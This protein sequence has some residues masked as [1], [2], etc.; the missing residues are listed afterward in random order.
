[1]FEA[2]E[3]VVISEGYGYR[4]ERFSKVERITKG[5][6]AE[7]EGQLYNPNGTRFGGS[8]TPRYL[9]KITPEVE[10]KVWASQARARAI[11]IVRSLAVRDRMSQEDAER[12]LALAEEMK[13][14]V[15]TPAK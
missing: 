5:G 7:V 8:G 13:T 10:A 2:G 11:E 3:R 1:M 4:S 9:V 6:K 15:S 12:F 14:L